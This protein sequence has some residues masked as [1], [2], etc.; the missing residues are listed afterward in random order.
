M[1][2]LPLGDAEVLGGREAPVQWCLGV[3]G[4]AVSFN[5]FPATVVVYILFSSSSQCSYFETGYVSLTFF[6]RHF[7]SILYSSPTPSFSVFV[8]CVSRSVSSSDLL[9]FPSADTRLSAIPVKE[10][11]WFARL[12]QHASWINDSG[13]R[14]VFLAG[15]V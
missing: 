2:A 12:H 4:L 8:P 5:P 1:Q 6:S 9:V 10:V 13:E 15:H 11:H 14:F 7:F 3:K